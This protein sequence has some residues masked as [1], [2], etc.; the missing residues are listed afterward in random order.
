MQDGGHAGGDLL[1]GLEPVA[2]LEHAGRAAVL[3]SHQ[4]Q[5]RRP[6][7][8]LT[9]E[10]LDPLV[11]VLEL[12]DGR[13]PVGEDDG[14]LGGRPP[15]RRDG[16][17]LAHPLRERV[18]DRVPGRGHAQAEP[19]EVRL[20]VVVVVPA[21]VLAHQ[22]E[23]EHGAGGKRDVL[24]GDED[25]LAI[26]VAAAGAGVDAPGGVVLAVDGELDP[27]GHPLA[28]RPSSKL[29]SRSRSSFA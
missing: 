27:A 23:R 10:R 2:P 4:G 24:L 13:P 17:D 11:G 15:G 7:G 22:V 14:L 1:A 12:G 19:A 28:A 20:L 29:D 5:C 3:A 21:A 25:R 18:G 16:Q 9:A 8:P 6:L 26:G